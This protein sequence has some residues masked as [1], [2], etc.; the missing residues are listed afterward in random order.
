MARASTGRL[1]AMIFLLHAS[2]LAGDC[3]EKLLEKLAGSGVRFITLEETMVDPFNHADA[4]LVTNKFYNQT[5]RWVA[6]KQLF[7]R[8]MPFRYS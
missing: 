4:G 6:L 8:R 3:T 5:Q 2:P 7:F 1:P